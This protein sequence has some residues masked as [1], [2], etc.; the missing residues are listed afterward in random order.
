MYMVAKEVARQNLTFCALQE[1]RHRNT[2]DEM[3]NL[4]NGEKYRFIWSGK[5]KRRDAGVGI[6]VKNDPSI[7]IED[8]D[9]SNSRI[10]ALNINIYGFKTRIVIAYSP[11]NADISVSTKESFYRD[12]RKACNKDNKNRKLIVLGD[13][14]AET[15]MVLKKTDY[16]GKSVLLDN[17]CNDNGEKL[18]SH[19]RQY[20]LCMTQSFFNHPLEE[21]YTWYSPDGITKKVLDYILVENFTQQFISECRTIQ[22]DKFISD[23]RLVI[24]S[25]KTPTN[26][27]TRWAPRAKKKSQLDISALEKSEIHEKLKISA[28]NNI[29]WED[30]NLSTT[31]LSDNL[32]EALQNAAKETLPKKTKEKTA[33]TW[34]FDST[35]N[36]LIE[37]RAKFNRGS[38]N[39]KEYTKKIKK[40][41]N[42]L[43]NDKLRTEASQIDKLAMKKEIEKLYRTFKED[44]NG[45]IKSRSNAKCDEQKL[46]IF[47]KDHFSKKNNADTPIELIAEPCIKAQLNGDSSSKINFEPPEKEEILSIMK[48]LKNNKASN[49]I[50]P[51]FIKCAAE[52]DKVIKEIVK[53]YKLVWK[54]KEVPEKWGL[55][56]L[57]ALWK[58]ASKGSASDPKAYRALQIGSTLCK[59]L[60]MII[61]ERLKDWYDK[62]LLDQQQGFR[63]KRGTND[64]IYLVKRLQQISNKTKKPIY[65]LFI[66]LTAAFDHV[67][68]EWLF[69]SIKKRFPNNQ[70]NILFQLL[71][72]LYSKTQTAI[73]GNMDLVFETFVGVRQGGP[74][75]PFL[76]NLYMDY[77]LRIFLLECSKS[78][79][80]F[81]KLNYLIP[82]EA[83]K[84]KS[85][86]NIGL[87]GKFTLDWIGYADDLVL[88]F[89]DQRSLQR[90]LHVLSDTF[91][92]YQLM[93]NVSKTKTMIFNYSGIEYPRTIAQLDNNALDNVD[94]FCYLGAQ[95][96][97][98]EHTT[99]DAEINFRI[100]SAENKFYEH[101]K[102]FLNK[103][104]SLRTR[105]EIFNSL[106]RSRLTYGCQ[107][108]TLSTK[109]ENQLNASYVRMLR[110]MIRQGFKR[111]EDSWAFTLTNNDIYNR[112]KTETLSTFIKR[113]Q[114]K[115]MTKVISSEDDS[116]IKRITFNSDA[117]H[118]RGPK[119]SLLQSVVANSS[120]SEAE[121][122]KKALPPV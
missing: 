37:T 48:K 30:D 110:M 82:G 71:E 24:A 107:T 6:L 9:F 22:E 106:V 118:Q 38:E 69:L 116:I 20:K 57:I 108:W 41:I 4:N 47:F 70:N 104:I 99:G 8:P 50:S 49:D 87:N 112:C 5:K 10:M 78:K 40:R 17:L 92:R 26:K 23:H 16:N 21:R 66:D 53:L 90:G 29:T 89:T 103:R 88:V 96:H 28:A 101:S 14:N 102:K 98:S 67:N 56:K 75:S 44:S 81:V 113:Q 114:E 74:E 64:G 51:S 84:N 13:F 19:C 39:F 42:K 15:N 60:V 55:S 76:Y 111:K 2:G 7:I 72:K 83:V 54:S 95:I 121:F 43:K 58:G 11:T 77:V 62:S 45:F 120:C 31:Q 117:S 119:R 65:A 25:L 52:S 79:L 59:I 33:E 94:V 18:K 46:S 100:D 85:N 3:I 91:K 63:P 32:I 12:L 61:L 122:F 86:F 68:R 115:F 109:H 105:V 73:N 34:K 36:S 80:D 27:G 93:I 35:F 1:V 97:R